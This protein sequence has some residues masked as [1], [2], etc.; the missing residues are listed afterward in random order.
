VANEEG[1]VEQLS[2][3]LGCRITN[4]AVGGYGPDQAYLRFRKAPDRSPVVLLGIDP[5]SIM[6]ILTQY[7]GFVGPELEPFLLKGRFILE[8]SGHLKWIPRPRLDLNGFIAMHRNPASV[9]PHSYFLPDTGDGPV[10]YRFPYTMTLARVA[11]MP[12]LRNVLL[13]R[14][15]WSSLYQAEDPSG[16]LQLMIAISDAFV[17]F[18]KAQGKRPLIVLLPVAGSFRERANYGEFE[19]APLIAALRAKNIDVFDPGAAM[20]AALDGRSACDLFTRQHT[21]MAWISSPLPC[22]GHYSALANTILARL[23]GTE[24]R[25]LNLLK[26]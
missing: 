14:S 7:D 23:V 21:G 16:G 18:A 6:D 4:Y 24:I 3:S 22:G 19:Y 25:H 13:R 5:N 8:P 11:L 12:R 26:P 20:V 10:T 17:E 9:L 1:W 2:H 15:E